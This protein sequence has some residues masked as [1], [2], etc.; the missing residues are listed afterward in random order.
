[1]IKPFRE[2]E[3]AM[4]Y[5]EYIAQ[6]LDNTIAYTEYLAEAISGKKGYSGYSGTHGVSGQSGISSSSG[7]SGFPVILGLT[8]NTWMSEYADAYK[9]EL[10]ILEDFQ[11]I[12]K[13]PLTDNEW[14]LKDYFQ[15]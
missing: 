9:K 14:S 15:L 12:E 3:N 11:I 8:N 4:S 1:M 10:P 2:F 7:V 6:N 13:K 5:T